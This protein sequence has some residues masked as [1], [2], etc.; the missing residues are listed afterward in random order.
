MYIINEHN[1]Y[2]DDQT[3]IYI[4]I[5]RPTTMGVKPKKRSTTQAAP[6]I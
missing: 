2:N 1:N 6:M 3:Y 5:Y 4:Y